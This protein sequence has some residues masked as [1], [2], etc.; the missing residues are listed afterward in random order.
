MMLHCQSPLL[1]E[2]DDRQNWLRVT[3][4]TPAGGHLTAT[5]VHSST[6]I[7]SLTRLTQPDANDL[8]RTLS[9]HM[10]YFSPCHTAVKS[11]MYNTLF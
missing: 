7:A 8:L 6:R 2:T 4:V 5:A 3:A 1:I 10:S 11:W 9:R